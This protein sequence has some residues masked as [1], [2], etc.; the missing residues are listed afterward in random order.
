MEN[1]PAYL[2][3]MVQQTKHAEKIEGANGIKEIPQ[4]YVG[5]GEDHSMS[6]DFKDVFD[7]A[8]EDAPIS[9]QEKQQNGICFASGRKLRAN[10][11]IQ[12]LLPDSGLIPIF[13]AMWQFVR[14]SSNDGRRLKTPTSTCHLKDP[15]VVRGTNLRRMRRNLV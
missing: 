6:F 4:D 12:A 15:M 1:E 7:F 14:E 8:V 2:L 11:L 10:F 3:K 5:M 13:R 9:T